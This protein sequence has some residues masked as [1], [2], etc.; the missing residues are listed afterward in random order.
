V[1]EPRPEVLPSGTQVVL[2]FRGAASMAKGPGTVLEPWLNAEFIDPYGDPFTTDQWVKKLKL[3]DNSFTVTE[4]PV[5]NDLTWR[6]SPAQLD[7][8][9]YIQVRASLISN[10]TSGLSPWMSALGLSYRR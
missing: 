6:S 10:P 1:V 4:F 3:P 2:A 7:G 5:N 9:R 8:A